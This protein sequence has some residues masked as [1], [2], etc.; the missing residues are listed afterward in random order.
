MKE[1]HSI[2]LRDLRENLKKDYLIGNRPVNKQ[3][4]ELKSKEKAFKS[5]K[6]YHK[7]EMTR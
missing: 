2:E 6:K 5:V 1:A 7:A 4:L 3:V